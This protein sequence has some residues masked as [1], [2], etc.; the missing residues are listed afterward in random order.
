M[1]VAV[2]TDAE[3][4]RFLKSLSLRY[5][6]VASGV[7]TSVILISIHSE[8]EPICPEHVPPPTKQSGKLQQI[9][10]R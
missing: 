10:H 6:G 3:S 5:I 7:V 1:T 8:A 2:V 4:L 9:V